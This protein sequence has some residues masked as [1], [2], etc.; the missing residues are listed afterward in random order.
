M[1]NLSIGVVATVVLAASACGQGEGASTSSNAPPVTVTVDEPIC[2]E[3][4]DVT[5]VPTYYE[6]V[7]PIIMEKCVGCH[8]PG[9]IA[10]FPLLTYEDTAPL[11]ALIKAR[12]TARE[13]PPFNPNNCGN[14]N[15]FKD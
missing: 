8:V 3:S 5:G 11:A 14:C 4:A 7:V 6:N 12:T 9:G 10:P 15:T 13:M 1:K 2:G